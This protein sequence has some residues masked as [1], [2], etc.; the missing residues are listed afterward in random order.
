[1]Q[2]ELAQQEKNS[3]IVEQADV[4]TVQFLDDFKRSWENDGKSNLDLP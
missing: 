1:M 3:N 4:L 2:R